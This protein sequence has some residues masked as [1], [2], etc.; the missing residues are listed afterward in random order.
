MKTF[1]EVSCF[2]RVNRIK[3]PFRAR[4]ISQ[5]LSRMQIQLPTGETVVVHAGAC[6]DDLSFTEPFPSLKRRAVK[7][8][9]Q[10]LK[11]RI[12]KPE[13]KKLTVKRKSISLMPEVFDV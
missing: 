11:K 10:P 4:V 5:R 12:V 2:Q 6:S 7:D 9:E 8:P 1:R 13:R 3:T